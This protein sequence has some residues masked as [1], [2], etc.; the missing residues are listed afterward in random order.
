MRA[1]ELLLQMI[2]QRWSSQFLLTDAAP[3]M[4]QDTTPTGSATAGSWLQTPS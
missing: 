3:L 1:M 4:Q 2:K